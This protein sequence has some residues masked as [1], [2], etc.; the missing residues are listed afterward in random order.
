ML[1]LSIGNGCNG[2]REKKD[3]GSLCDDIS[4]PDF[5]GALPD[6]SV[7]MEHDFFWRLK[8]G[9]SPSESL[10]N[11][12]IGSNFSTFTTCNT[13][14]RGRIGETRGGG[15]RGVVCATYGISTVELSD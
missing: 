2:G 9:D 8:L 7:W 4:D 5:I 12:M 15:L 1:T 3:F 6:S 11:S 14:G 13:T 10:D